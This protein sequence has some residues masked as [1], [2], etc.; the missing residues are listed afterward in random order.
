MKPGDIVQVVSARDQPPWTRRFVGKIGLVIKNLGPDDGVTSSP[1]IW[2]VLI[3]G[4]FYDLHLLDIE[5]ID[6]AG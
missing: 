3:D 6:E 4:N 2:S 1:N 5:K